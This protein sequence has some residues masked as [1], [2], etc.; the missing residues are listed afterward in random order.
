MK[1]NK[2]DSMAELLPEGLGEDT[3]TEI[4][5]LV[6][7]VI[8]EQVDTRMRTL[9]AKVQGYLR[10]KMDSIKEHAIKELETENEIYRNAKIFESL[11]TLMALELSSK[12]E[13]NAINNSVEEQAQ[14]QEENDLLVSELSDAL[15]ENTKLDNLVQALSNE[16]T[17]LEKR[18]DY[19]HDEVH[20]LEE[21]TQ[22]PFRSSEKAVIITENVD[23]EITV[24]P[25]QATG[26]EWL[27][28]DV[29]A[30]MPFND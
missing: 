15:V 8:T 9:E 17:T 11:K 14:V 22:K 25:T 3:I 1:K 18:N 21:S 16:L 20:T 5:E 19:L 24:S 28:N 12:D 13:E 10:M 4:C 7:E 2:M 29:M 6:N 27:T 23:E 26:N 30:F